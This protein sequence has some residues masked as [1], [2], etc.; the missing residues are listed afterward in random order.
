MGGVNIARLAIRHLLLIGWALVCAPSASAALFLETVVGDQ[1]DLF[2]KSNAII[3]SVNSVDISWSFD[4]AVLGLVGQPAFEGALTDPTFEL[5][6]C[7]MTCGGFFDPA[8]PLPAGT[9]MSWVFEWNVPPRTT[10][11]SVFVS[12]DEEL[13]PLRLDAT[14]AIPEPPTTA[15]MVAGIG[16]L[17]FWT[18]RRRGF[19]VNNELSLAP[20]SHR[21]G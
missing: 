2:L 8:M 19:Q 18:V 17:G 9:L 11:I 3:E 13:H 16:L 1:I 4:T 6:S 21:L 7:G 10:T 5:A 15:L 20:F 12:L 14:L